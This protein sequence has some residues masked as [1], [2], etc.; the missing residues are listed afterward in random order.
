M[1]AVAYTWHATCTCLFATWRLR[2][3]AC[4]VAFVACFAGWRTRSARPLMR[5][6]RSPPVSAQ[7][8]H[9]SHPHAAWYPA[10]LGTS[11]TAAWHRTFSMTPAPMKCTTSFRMPRG[12]SIR[13]RRSSNTRCCDLCGVSNRARVHLFARACMHARARA[14]IPRAFV[15]VVDAPAQLAR[16]LAIAHV[17]VDRRDLRLDL[18][19]NEH[20][21]T[22]HNALA[23][24]RGFAPATSCTGTG[25]I[26]HICTG[27]GLAPFT[28]SARVLTSHV[29]MARWRVRRVRRVRRR[30]DSLLTFAQP[31][32]GS[33]RLKFVGSDGR[34]CDDE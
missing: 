9:K 33:L 27:T 13:I 16:Q 31:S 19:T 4:D 18:Q 32:T 12:R 1:C 10:R 26:Y 23:L 24:R 15:V 2:R 17:L 21:T 29:V 14:R 20:N 30:H 7:R 11:P 34:T 8:G 28:R 25:R 6:A 22:Q 5:R 3:G